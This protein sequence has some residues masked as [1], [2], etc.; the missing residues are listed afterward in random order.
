MKTTFELQN[1]WRTA[2]YAFPSGPYIQRRILPQIL[3]DLSKPH[4]TV[5]LGARQVGKTFLLR[6][7]IQSLIVDQTVSPEQIF[8][9]NFDAFDLIELV[10]K[11]ADLLAFIDY[12]GTKGHNA[13]VFWDEAQRIPDVGLLA[14]R[15]QD[16]G[17]NIKLIISGSSSL[18]IKSQ[19]KESLAGRKR[20][21]EIN[22]VSYREFLAYKGVALPEDLA[23]T[24]RFESQRFERLLEEFVIFGGYPGV[25]VEERSQ[26]KAALL[27][28]IYQ[29]YVQKD[30]SDF[31]KI[32]DVAGFNRMVQFLAAQ[33]GALL[34]VNEVAKNVRLSRH[35]V[36][37]YLLAL[38]ETYVVAMLRPHFANLGKAIVKTPK[39]YFYDTGLRNAVF[40]TFESLNARTDAGALVEGFVFCELLK[41]VDRDR[42]WYYR[43]TTGTEIDFCIVK[44][45]KSFPLEV[46]YRA[47][48]QRTAPKAFETISR[49]L[50]QD[51]AL[52]VTRD[53]LGQQEAAGLHVAFRPAWSFFDVCQIVEI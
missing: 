41:A 20:V 8:Y 7:L 26:D 21:F 32:E 3:A 42:L 45:G 11:E 4:A 18:Q 46:K 9:F 39:L 43:T 15:Y 16:L 6:K 12:Y 28:E 36:E 19:V 23:A 37:K 2:D 29:S 5:L 33:A 10:K 1:P 44:G 47:V 14:K 13:F 25:V 53:Y 35:F 49:H 27:R 17:L 50:G 48:R 52:L 51:R 24:A 31:L 22:P 38:E 34:K 30:I 40:G